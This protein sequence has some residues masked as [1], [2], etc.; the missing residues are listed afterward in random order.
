MSRIYIVSSRAD[1]SVVRLVR[2]N[3]LNSAV[4]ALAD[5]LYTAAAATH[6]ELFEAARA[7]EF[8]VLNAIE[9]KE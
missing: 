2:A 7:G 8:K 5:E 6:D 9:E 1:K 3:T 4:R